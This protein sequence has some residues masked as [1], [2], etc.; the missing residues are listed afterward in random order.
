MIDTT[1]KMREIV[2]EE[3]LFGEFLVSKGFPFTIKNPL[4]ALVNFDQVAEMKKLD[5][6]AF[7]AEYEA[8]KAAWT[9]EA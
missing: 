1:K 9:E 3:P 4:T 6:E 2:K 5:K 7:L 8:W